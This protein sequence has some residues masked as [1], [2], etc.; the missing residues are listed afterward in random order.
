MQ[1]HNWRGGKIMK[2]MLMAM[3]VVAVSFMATNAFSGDCGD[4]NNSTGVN[5]LDIT[6]LINFLYKT[7]AG[8]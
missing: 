6:Y 2:R 8:A 1:F 7:W 5:A 4:V 3:L